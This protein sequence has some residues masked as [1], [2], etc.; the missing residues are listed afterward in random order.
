MK[1]GRSVLKVLTAVACAG[2]L[3]S[4]VA[5][6]VWFTHDV[7]TFG[8]APP[9]ANGVFNA[10]DVQ[11]VFFSSSFIRFPGGPNVGNTLVGNNPAV[12][13][14]LP[15]DNIDAIH[16]ELRPLSDD[17][18]FFPAFVFSVDPIGIGQ[19]GSA[20]AA[21]SPSNAGDL[22][23]SNGVVQALDL[24][25]F[26]PGLVTQ[27]RTDIDGIFLTPLANVNVGGF[28]YFSLTPGSPTLA[29]LGASP[30]DILAA[31]VGGPP[32][33]SIAAKDIGLDEHDDLDA[34]VMLNGVDANADGDFNDPGDGSPM[35]LFSV[36]H[37]SQGLLGTAVRNQATTDFPPG[38][39]IF[40]SIASTGTNT[41]GKDDFNLGLADRD[42]LNALDLASLAVPPGTVG[43]GIII[44]PGTPFGGGMT[45][46]GTPPGGGGGAGGP[47]PGGGTVNCVRVGLCKSMSSTGKC[48]LTLR[49]GLTCG[50]VEIKLTVDCDDCDDSNGSEHTAAVT[51]MALA[52]AGAQV[53][54]GPDMGMNIFAGP[55]VVNRTSP[56][57]INATLQVN[58]MLTS[59]GV[60]SVT[61]QRDNCPCYTQNVKPKN[62]VAPG[63]GPGMTCIWLG[64]GKIEPG[65]YMIQ[66]GED[67]EPF[68]I[69]L[70]GGTPED[71]AEQLAEFLTDLGYD[72]KISEEDPAKLIIHDVTD[73]WGI[74]WLSGGGMGHTVIVTI[75]PTDD[76][77]G[78]DAMSALFQRW[79]TKARPGSPLDADNSGVIDLADLMELLG[80]RD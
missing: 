48:E 28:F 49:I 11:D 37:F 73:I 77:A 52:L 46:P 31:P 67:G 15:G 47:P 64:E 24:N 23:E 72:V 22:F 69:E 36:S 54:S 51:A 63:G 8:I 7:N 34:L 58:A 45:T 12:F 13:G 6:D 68:I 40:F 35:V 19:P 76:D 26:Q 55:G 56:T 38:G 33:I 18:E 17:A 42:N 9:P 74:G 14:L 61:V 53:P 20:V 78:S 27:P 43:D 62:T 65:E 79:G 50:Q 2:A 21:Q 32:V 70:A 57:H 80:E 5:G 4:A 3:G 29:A 10:P 71:A 1:H 75:F 39:D 66:F 16:H 30:A 25:E 41:L 59:C 60:Q 44:P